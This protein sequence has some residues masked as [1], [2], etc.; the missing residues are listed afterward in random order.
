MIGFKQNGAFEKTKKFLQEAQKIK[1]LKT[2]ASIEASAARGVEALQ[3][4]TPK[5]TGA[6]AAS[7]SYEI[8]EKENKIIVAWTNDNVVNGVNIAIIL[9]YG[10]AT[11]NGSRVEGIDY[12]NPALRSIFT[13]MSDDM[14]KAVVS[15]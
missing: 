6:T 13:K 14:W 11:K 2:R 4:A 10:H 1:Q 5:K 7:W 3:K 15:L 12:I 8:E 9:Q